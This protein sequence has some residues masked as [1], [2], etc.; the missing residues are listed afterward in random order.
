MANRL[1]L[2]AKSYSPAVV[3]TKIS[4]FAGVI[5][6]FGGPGTTGVVGSVGAVQLTSSAH[7]DELYWQMSVD[8][9]DV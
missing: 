8:R 9:S 1:F 4:G 2:I 5:P 3:F 7:N 6:V